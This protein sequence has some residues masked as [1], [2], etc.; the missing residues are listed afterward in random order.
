MSWN[1]SVNKVTGCRLHDQFSCQLGWGFSSLLPATM[2]RQALESTQPCTQLV[3]GA[4]LEVKHPEHEAY[5]SPP[6]SAKVKNGD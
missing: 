4:L 6:S 2:S 3:P 1:S 5:H